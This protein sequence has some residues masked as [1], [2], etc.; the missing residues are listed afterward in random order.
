MAV[1]RPVSKHIKAYGQLLETRDG[2]ATTVMCDVVLSG[3][4]DVSRAFGPSLYD[5]PD[6]NQVLGEIQLPDGHRE[7]LSSYTGYILLLQQGRIECKINVEA[8]GK[9]LTYK[10]RGTI[11]EV[12]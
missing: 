4:R 7:H 9:L 8:S 6:W 3:T 10:I 2:P 5:R 1:I 11:I 12:A